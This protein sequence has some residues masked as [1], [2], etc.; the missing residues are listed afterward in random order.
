MSSKIASMV[1]LQ[2]SAGAFAL[3]TAGHVIVAHGDPGGNW[4]TRP[5]HP[6]LS[7]HDSRTGPSASAI[8]GLVGGW[9]GRA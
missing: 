7:V 5:A 4:S 6:R 8:A 9:D 2:S 1:L 3:A